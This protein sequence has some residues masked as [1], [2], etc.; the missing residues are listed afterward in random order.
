MKARANFTLE[1]RVVSTPMIVLINVGI[2]GIRNDQHGRTLVSADRAGNR[3]AR[4]LTT[5]RDQPRASSPINDSYCVNRVISGLLAGSTLQ[6]QTDTFV[7]LNVVPCVPTAPGHSQ[8]KEVSPGAVVCLSQRNYKIKSVKLASCVTLL[9]CVKPVVNARN[10]VS[11]P[12]VGARLQGFWQV[13]LKL[14]ASY[15][16]VQILRSGYTLPFQNRPLLSRRPTV[17]SRYVNHHRN[18][19][20]SEALHQLISKNAVEPV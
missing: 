11:N 6:R 2:T 9:S 16:V 12:P 8:K 5:P 20:L 4:P 19:Y 13:W 3:R 18:S 1:R 7:D 10:V 14:G 15:K 17:I